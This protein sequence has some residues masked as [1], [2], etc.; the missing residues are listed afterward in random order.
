MPTM[1][2]APRALND[3]SALQ[4]GWHPAY[5]M[6]ITD[7]ETPEGW[8]MKPNSPRLW[9]WRF[10]VWAKPADI[11]TLRPEFQNAVS[12]QAFS[13]GGGGKSVAKAYSWASELIGHKPQPGEAVNLDALMPCP[14]RVK[15]ER[16]TTNPDYSNIIDLENSE[17]TWPEVAAYLANEAFK[18]QLLAFYAQGPE[19]P[20]DGSGTQRPA[21]PPPTQPPRAQAQ[22]PPQPGMP[23]WGG[24]PTPAATV[25]TSKTGW[26]QSR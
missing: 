3:K 10:L 9:R 21:P 2:Y 14:C 8:K 16:S 23:V 24:I 22:T 17:D 1:T 20:P 15:M 5:L 6:E 12:S 13:P 19:A 11:P 4:D 7:E 25:T 18:T 26:G